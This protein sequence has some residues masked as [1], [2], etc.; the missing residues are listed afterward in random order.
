MDVNWPFKSTIYST[1]QSSKFHR[2][3]VTGFVHQNLLWLSVCCRD[4][5]DL[6]DLMD[7]SGQ[8]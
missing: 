1:G 2:P 6:L 7:V 5:Q 3:F 4:I 8:L